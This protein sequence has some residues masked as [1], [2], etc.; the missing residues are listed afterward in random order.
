MQGTVKLT[1]GHSHSSIYRQ[2]CSRIRHTATQIRYATVNVRATHDSATRSDLAR[3]IRDP[4]D[5]R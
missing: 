4:K 2:Q 3:G 5:I 1:E